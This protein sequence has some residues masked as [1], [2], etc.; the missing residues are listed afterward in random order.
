MV[1][2]VTAL[3]AGACGSDRKGKPRLVVSAAASLNEALTSCGG[4]F[5]D[6]HIRF[7]FAG[8]DELAAQI[9]QGAKPDVFA[10]ANTKLP[11]ELRAD[12]LLEKPVVF[13]TNELVLAV[14]SGSDRVASVEDLTRPGTKLALGSK[15]VPIGSYTRDLLAR[16]PA[17]KRNAILDNVRSEEPDVKGVV[18]KL[19][20]KAVDAGFVYRSDV[21]ATKGALRAIDLPKA[22]QPTVSY[23]AGV[24]TGTKRGPLAKEFVS[25]LVSGPCAK[26]LRH[27]K[28]GPPSEP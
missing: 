10:A 26:A 24:V 6:A 5:N 17:N 16:L 1:V 11:D 18:G 13:A 4:Q 2:A 22:L 8:S 9:R 27:A 7:S 14:P 21:A 28:F 20:Q 3:L 15:S 25:E 23:G 19:T 12:G